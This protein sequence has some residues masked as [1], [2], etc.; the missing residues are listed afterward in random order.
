MRVSDELQPGNAEF[1]KGEET[2][3]RLTRLS[4]MKFSVHAAGA[5]DEAAAATA[6]AS[7]TLEGY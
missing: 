4:V 6:A 7:G 3:V 1:A 5:A 2:L